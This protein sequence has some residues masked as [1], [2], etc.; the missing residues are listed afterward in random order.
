MC[1]VGVSVSVSV[2][3]SAMQCCVSAVSVLCL[4]GTGDSPIVLLI[5]VSALYLQ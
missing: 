1:S 3:V 2:S 4:L 5:D